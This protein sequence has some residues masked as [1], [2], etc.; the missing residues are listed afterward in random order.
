MA[1]ASIVE[2]R[3]NGTGS[4]TNTKAAAAPASASKEPTASAQSTS[5]P[6]TTP[7]MVGM[8]AA[9]RAAARK[10]KRAPS[11]EQR[12]AHLRAIE[13]LLVKNQEVIAEAI[14][15][16]FSHRATQETRMTEI[17]MPV[18][19]ARHT[20]EHLAEW[21]SIQDRE[22]HIMTMTGRSELRPQP[23]GVV[24]IIA[25]WNYPVQLAFAPLIQ[26]IAAG[27]RAML[28]PSEFTPATSDLI[29]RLISETFSPEEVCVVT[30]DADVGQAFAK[31]PFDHLVFT[32]STQVGK[33]VMK[34]AAEN[35]V[36]VTLELGGKSPS[37]VGPKFS[38]DR[39]AAAIMHG[40]VFNAGQTCVAPD[41]ALVPRK[42]VPAFVAAC[43]VAVQKMFSSLEKN[44][45]YTAVVNER[46]LGRLRSYLEEAKQKGAE[47]VELNV[48]DRMERK[49]APTLVLEPSDDM[50]VMQ[51]EIF[52]PILPI[53]PYD[54]LDEAIAYV[55]DRP[56]PLALYLF[57]D[58]S[59]IVEQVLEETISGG[60]TVNDF[61]M[62]VVQD[63]L[64][65]GGVGA[66]G[67]GHYH[68]REGFEAFS[69]MKPVFYQLR[70]NGEAPS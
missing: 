64:P 8:L 22:S 39:A 42:Q 18:S 38:V 41:Y 43:K 47:V 55:N 57:E 20:R 14:S 29:K 5:T 6:A 7:D 62:H 21:M 44:P 58:D 46:H 59:Q 67:M 54:T 31:L 35:L 49:M 9:M 63:A 45:D 30:G 25:P 1:N 27:N 48:G 40:K 24:G 23:L 65:F 53:V 4:G 3:S 2:E 33:L 15:K 69:K 26:A 10:S 11:L 60:V 37:I 16:D 52:G 19:L 36:P 34:A 12:L 17:M 50:R 70:L 61:G 51:D 32:G 13:N 68:G 66:S 56:R 28:K